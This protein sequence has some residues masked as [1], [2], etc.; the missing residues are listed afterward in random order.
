MSDPER[1]TGAEQEGESSTNYADMLREAKQEQE[2]EPQSAE[3]LEQQAAGQLL[4]PIE[5]GVARLTARQAEI[6]EQNKQA[7]EDASRYRQA[8][9]ANRGVAFS[10]PNLVYDP[11]A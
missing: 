11:V 9:G 2:G 1:Q 3:K 10:D 5:A 8:G 6:N 7:T 4:A